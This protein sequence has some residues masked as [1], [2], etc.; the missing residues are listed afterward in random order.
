MNDKLKALGY[1]KVASGWVKQTITTTI[2]VDHQVV[3]LEDNTL[4]TKL[5][6]TRYRK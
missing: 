5:S 3:L 4:G 2:T 1:T 6:I